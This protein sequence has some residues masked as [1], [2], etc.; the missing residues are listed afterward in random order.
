MHTVTVTVRS[1][2]SNPIPINKRTKIPASHADYHEHIA[3]HTSF[4]VQITRGR[5]LQINASTAQLLL[6][7]EN[8]V[9]IIR[10]VFNHV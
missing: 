5:F 9:R 7:Q 6:T 3:K 1:V 4:K 10:K 2:S 8:S